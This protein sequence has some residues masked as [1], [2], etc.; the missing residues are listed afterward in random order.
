[1]RKMTVKSWALLGLIICFLCNLAYVSSVQAAEIIRETIPLERNNVKLHLERYVEQDGQTKK[2]I[3]FVHGL[4]FS[5]HEFDVD[6]KDY[7]LA[8]YFAKHNFEVWLL[9]IAGYGNSAAVKDG[10]M[11]NSDYASEDIEAAVRC[12]LARNNCQSM[13]V[14]GWSWGT[15]TSGRFAARHPELVHRLVLYA[16][17]VAGLGEKEVLEPFHHNTWED[18]ASDFQREKDGEIDLDIV[19]RPVASTYIDNAWH[20]DRDVSPNGGRR[21]LLVDKSARLI[22]T[23]SIKAPVLI[24]VGS[25]DPYVSPDLCDE[26]YRTLPNRTDS[27]LIILDGAAH[28]MLMER[29]YYKLFRE[30]VLNFLNKG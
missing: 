6:Y 26:A 23:E 3:L 8:K 19:E 15:V 9:D 29:P 5:S 18:A 7:S 12:I 4:T 22:P 14:L 20:Y 28:A 1:M 17:I 30:R 13:D 24:I 25:K 11:P 21:D 27:E 16:P 10:F 2:P